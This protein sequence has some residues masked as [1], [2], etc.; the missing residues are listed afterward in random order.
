VRTRTVTSTVLTL[1]VGADGVAKG[2]AL[3]VQS[4]RSGTLSITGTDSSGRTVRFA[5][6][7]RVG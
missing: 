2:S 3:P 6:D 1:R 5:T 4:V 7:V